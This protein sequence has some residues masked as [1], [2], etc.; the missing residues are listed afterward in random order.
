MAHE[1]EINAMAAA[2]VQAHDGKAYFNFREISEIVGCGI[3]TV[4]RVL[5]EAG[6]G[7]KRIGTSKRISAYDLAEFMCLYRVAAID[8]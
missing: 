1:K 5:H 6:V 7:V 4:P 2:I 3:N 8:K